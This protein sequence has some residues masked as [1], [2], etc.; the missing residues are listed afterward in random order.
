MKTSKKGLPPGTIVYT[1]DQKVEKTMIN[2]YL[3]SQERIEVVKEVQLD[4]L[5]GL[6]KREDC[7]SWVDIRGL[8]DIEL[9][10]RIGKEAEIHPLIM[11]DIADVHQRPKYESLE[12]GAFLVLQAMYFNKHD[13]F[14]SEQVSMYVTPYY[15]IS[16]QEKKEDVFETV[17]LRLIENRGIIRQKATDYL[18]YS[19]IDVIVDDYFETLDKLETRVFAIEQDILDNKTDDIKERLHAARAI[20]VKMSKSVLPWRDAVLKTMKLDD[21]TFGESVLPYLRDLYDHTVQVIDRQETLRDII[22]G[23]RDLYHS[24][25]NLAM[26]KIM[27]VL[28]IIS[29]IFIPLTFLVGV[30]GMNF[31]NI[32]ELKWKFGYPMVW[33]VMVMMALLLL[34]WFKRKKWF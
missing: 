13:L 17:K 6:L 15:L 5:D 26:N 1:G 27:Q 25:L 22:N 33:V 12:N 16:F 7:I 8:H 30:Y 10:Q 18:A 14:R 24:E 3:Y 4:D 2:V 20:L 29:T 34:K 28:T 11:E 23:L 31:E 9:L 32:P 19:L 21:L